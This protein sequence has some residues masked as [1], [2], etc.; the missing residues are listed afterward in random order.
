MMNEKIKHLIMQRANAGQIKQ[1]ALEIGMRTLR[2]DGMYR[3]LQGKT[4]VDECL[5]VA[6]EEEVIEA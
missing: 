1:V 4:T 5:R 2:M 3:V 6:Q